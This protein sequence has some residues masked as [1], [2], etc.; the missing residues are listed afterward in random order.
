MVVVLRCEVGLL[1]FALD[2]CSAMVQELD[3]PEIRGQIHVTS[4]LN[5]AFFRKMFCFEKKKILFCKQEI[6]N[7]L[8]NFMIVLS[9]LAVLLIIATTASLS[10]RNK[11][12][13]F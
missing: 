12:F 3:I 5:I 11:S 7:L 1:E 13:W 8:I 2:F 9:L 10:A 6:T 4:P